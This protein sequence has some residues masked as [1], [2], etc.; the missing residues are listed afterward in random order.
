MSE[1]ILIWYAITFQT[2]LLSKIHIY[3]NCTLYTGQDNENERA[4]SICIRFFYLRIFQNPNSI[5]WRIRNFFFPTVNAKVSIDI[6]IRIQIHFP[7]KRKVCL[8]A[9]KFRILN[10]FL[11]RDRQSRHVADRQRWL[12][13]KIISHLKVKR[14]LILGTCMR[15]LFHANQ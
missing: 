5:L 14:C 1:F 12:L 4:S 10:Q 6:F 8:L 13:I 11:W 3:L 2:K 9:V 15:I 7:Y